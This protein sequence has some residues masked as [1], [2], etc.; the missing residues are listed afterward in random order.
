MRLGGILNVKYDCQ[1]GVKAG[2]TIKFIL[3]NSLRIVARSMRSAG[4]PPGQK[5]VFFAYKLY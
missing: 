3:S 5:R 1:S 2:F 4:E